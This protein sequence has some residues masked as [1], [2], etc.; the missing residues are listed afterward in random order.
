LPIDLHFSLQVVTVKNMKATNIFQIPEIARLMKAE[1]EATC[2]DAKREY[3]NAWIRLA[4][5]E[6]VRRGQRTRA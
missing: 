5:A 6:Q 2:P 1:R 4:K 3:H